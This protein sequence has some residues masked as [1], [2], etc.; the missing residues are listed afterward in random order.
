M[1]IRIKSLDHL[2]I[3]A[4]NLQATID[5]YTQVLG[6]AHVAFGDNLHAVHFGD[7]KFNIHDASTDVSPK[8]VNIVPGSED[9]CLISETS[10]SLVIQHLTDC[11]VAIEEG[12]VTRSGAT[13]TLES[14]YFRDPDG[15]LLEVSN[16][17]G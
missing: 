2:V 17:I 9:F 7:Q 14:V 13:G 1:T 4:S 3:T 5:F 15:N 11:G 12:P 10:V 8:A 16:V 6:M